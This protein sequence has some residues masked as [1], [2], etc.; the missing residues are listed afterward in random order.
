MDEVRN[1]FA[2]GAGTQPPELA[3]RDGII[4]E[5]RIALQRAV[6]GRS[7]RSQ[8][9]LGLRGVGKTVLLNRIQEMAEDEDHLTSFIE[10][11][12][13]NRIVDLL[14]PRLVQV[15]RKLSTTERARASAHSGMRAL[16]SFASAFKIEIGDISLSVDPESGTADSGNL[17]FDLSDLFLKIGEAAKSAGRAWTLLIDE[18]QYLSSDDLSALIVALHRANQKALPI[19]FFGA[20]LPQAAALSGEA[21]SYAERLFTYPTVGALNAADAQAAIRGPVEEEGETITD[22][23]IRNIVVKTQGYPYFLQEWG[24][25]VWNTADASP[26]SGDDVDTASVDAIRRLD[27]GFFRVRFDRLT[28]KERDYVIC[29]AELGS[30]PYRSGDV[31]E[32]MGEKVTSLGPTR[33]SIIRKGM[34]YSPSHGDIDFTVPLFADYLHRTREIDCG[35]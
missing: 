27:E 3:G 6:R 35:A 34:I 25:Q 22:D 8:M 19:L 31:A 30:G 4:S 23:A 15:L 10:A 18:V 21:K 12:E 9:L 28:P 13:S 2:P 11:P 7:S 1:P 29:M 20:G 24:Y 26:I 17:E 14:Y 33:S 5:A 32:R 16:R